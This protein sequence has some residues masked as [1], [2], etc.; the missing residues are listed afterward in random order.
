MENTISL[1]FLGHVQLASTA[2]ADLMFRTLQEITLQDALVISMAVFARLGLFV[3]LPLH[4]RSRVLPVLTTI[5]CS[6]KAVLF[7]PV[8]HFAPVIRL[9]TS[10]APK[11]TIA[12]MVLSSI[13]S[14][15]VH[16]ERLTTRQRGIHTATV[17][18][19]LLGISQVAPEISFPM[20]SVVVGIIVR[21]AQSH[22]RRLVPVL[23]A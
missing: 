9:V 21:V 11:A 8:A 2:K 13:F 12:R 23:S 18:Q 19:L 4:F 20:E 7:A 16:K 10:I 5:S 6:K 14:T 1:Q 17:L 15:H 3:Q 22:L